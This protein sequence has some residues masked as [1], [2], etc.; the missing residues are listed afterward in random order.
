M[1]YS[2][3]HTDAEVAALYRDGKYAKPKDLFRASAE[4]RLFGPTKLFYRMREKICATS[5]KVL[6]QKR[7]RQAPVVEEPD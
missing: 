2:S 3:P 4:I 6:L 1:S 7:G 5:M